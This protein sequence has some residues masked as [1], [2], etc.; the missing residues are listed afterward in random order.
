MLLVELE[1]TKHL[2]AK[3]LNAITEHSEVTTRR[4]K[5]AYLK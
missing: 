1:T 4:K 2:I 3:P 5:N